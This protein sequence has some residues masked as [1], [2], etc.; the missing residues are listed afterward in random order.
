LIEAD[1]QTL[2]IPRKSDQTLVVSDLLFEL[3]TK[4]EDTISV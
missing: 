2:E 1:L 3:A 4:H